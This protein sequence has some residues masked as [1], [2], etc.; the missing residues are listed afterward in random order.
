MREFIIILIMMKQRGLLLVWD[1]SSVCFTPLRSWLK[2]DGTTLELP[3]TTSVDEVCALEGT[4]S[5]LQS[6]RLRS[7]GLSSGVLQ[8]L[9]RVLQ[10]ASVLH[11]LIVQFHVSATVLTSLCQTLRSSLCHLY[12]WVN[13]EDSEETDTQHLCGLLGNVNLSALFL[14]S[15]FPGPAQ[16]GIWV[17]EAV[18]RM[19]SLRALQM[20]CKGAEFVSQF[21]KLLVAPQLQLLH[22]AQWGQ[23]SADEVRDLC[24]SCASMSMLQELNVKLKDGAAFSAFAVGCIPL[25]QSSL[26]TL[27]CDVAAWNIADR[28]VLDFFF[29]LRDKSRLRSLTVPTSYIRD[30]LVICSGILDAGWL[31]D[32]APQSS[33]IKELLDRNLQRHHACARACTT[34]IVVRKSKRALASI[35]REI[36][37]QIVRFMWETRNE[38]F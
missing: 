5:R 6:L 33:Q 18:S 34:L 26:T 37:L 1:D 8:Q 17:A 10:S 23:L 21:C 35:P 7:G 36:V 27:K 29:L 4:V 31:T 30:E 38:Y 28:D 15:H 13:F 16:L 3:H 14:G 24:K 20:N 19:H 2:S 22:V 11:T 25:I 9:L 32:M 12:V